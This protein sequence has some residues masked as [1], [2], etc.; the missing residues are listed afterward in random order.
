MRLTVPCFAPQNFV[1]EVW[2]CRVPH[3]VTDKVESNA[4]KEHYTELVITS[5]ICGVFHPGAG[6][7]NWNIG[8]DSDDSGGLEQTILGSRER[9]RE[10][11][12]PGQISAHTGNWQSVRRRRELRLSM[13]EKRG[14]CLQQGTVGSSDGVCFA[15]EVM[16]GARWCQGLSVMLI[17]YS[18]QSE[19]SIHDYSCHCVLD[20]NR[21]INYLFPPSES[22]LAAWLLLA[23]H[24]MDLS[25]QWGA[26]LPSWSKIITLVRLAEMTPR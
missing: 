14:D 9:E 13:R 17:S 11:L 16:T 26:A 2:L 25:P 4:V 22:A 19:A 21:I 8:A 12:S 6:V 10:L 18:V 24:M 20:T 3:K 7:G 5:L 15:Q 23:V 1:Y